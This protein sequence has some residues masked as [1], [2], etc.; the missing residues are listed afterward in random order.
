VGEMQIGKVLYELINISYQKALRLP[1]E[2]TL[3]AKT[4]FNL[5]AVTRA[6]DPM[7]S[8]IPTI[9]E[10]GNEIMTERA[11]R[12]LSP[13]R[14]FE[15]ATQGSD[16]LMALPHRLDLIS[17]RLAAGDFEMR[18]DVPQL[19]VVMTGMQKVAN[20]IFSGLVV[21]AI[22]VAS[23]MLMP[24]RRT[25]STYGFIL[26]AVLGIWMVLTIVWTDRKDD[27]RKSRELQ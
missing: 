1:A 19:V 23:A 4:L 7:Y 17:G 9:R 25:L 2:L 21:A 15:L 20:R 16:L 24:Y 18:M 11:K 14:L 12:D 6:I 5:D 13:R 10:Y 8:P 22:I 3:L 27:K 26:S